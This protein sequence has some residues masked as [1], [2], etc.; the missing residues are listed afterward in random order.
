MVED[1]NNEWYQILGI[2]GPESYAFHKCPLRPH[3]VPG[4][5]L[6]T[7]LCTCRFPPS[8][9][10]LPHEPRELPSHL[11]HVILLRTD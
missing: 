6:G 11:I 3:C 7:G 9:G 1:V 8:L 2:L 10:F 5:W 4:R